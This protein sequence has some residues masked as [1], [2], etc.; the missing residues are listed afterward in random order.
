MQVRRENK[1]VISG[2]E[3]SYFQK[4]WAQEEKQETRWVVGLLEKFSR[5][6]QKH[7]RCSK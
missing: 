6:N 5:V 4:D 1:G 2:T 3:Q 7:M